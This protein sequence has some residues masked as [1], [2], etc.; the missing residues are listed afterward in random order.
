MDINQSN[1]INTL[2]ILLRCSFF[3]HEYTLEG[4]IE[5]KNIELKQQIID[6]DSNYVHQRVLIVHHLSNLFETFLITNTEDIHFIM[7]KG[8][9]YVSKYFSD[10]ILPNNFERSKDLLEMFVDTSFDTSFNK[11]EISK[12]AI[13]F[14]SGYTDSL[15]LLTLT[16]KNTL[17]SIFKKCIDD[18]KLLT[19]EY[20]YYVQHYFIETYDYEYELLSK[21]NK[22]VF[23]TKLTNKS[24]IHFL[25]IIFHKLYNKKYYLLNDFFY[26]KRILNLHHLGE[27]ISTITCDE[28]ISLFNSIDISEYISESGTIPDELNNFKSRKKQKVYALSDIKKLV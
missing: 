6:E 26:F 7:K 19:N 27:N 5:D 2:S 22:I 14:F 3:Y 13:C 15:D 20:K 11:I 28:I 16:L 10:N 25:M 9:L 8:N 21:D 12:E 24:M 17:I 4:L 23:K 18:E 1:L